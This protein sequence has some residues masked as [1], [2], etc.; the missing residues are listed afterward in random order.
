MES[1]WE[2]PIALSDEPPSTSF[3]MESL[4]NEPLPIV[5]CYWSASSDDNASDEELG[6]DATR[7]QHEQEL[8]TALSLDVSEQLDDGNWP[9]QSNQQVPPSSPLRLPSPPPA[10]DED[11]SDEATSE[12]HPESLPTKPRTRK[13]AINPE[14]IPAMLK[15]F[16]ATLNKYFTQPINLQRTAPPVSNS[17]MTKAMERIY[18]K[19]DLSHAF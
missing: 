9:S 1:S 6:D 13:Y 4:E 12:G 19:Y 17:T 2:R 5:N 7:S 18:C 3:E 10:V 16:L 11:S 8:K 14:H 15:A